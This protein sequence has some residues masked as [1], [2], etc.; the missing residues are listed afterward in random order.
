MRRQYHVDYDALPAATRDVLIDS[1]LALETAAH[2]G[3]KD[4]MKV[5]GITADAPELAGADLCA[6]GGFFDYKYR[7][8]DYDVGRKKAQAFLIDPH[9]PL[10]RIAFAPEPIDPIDATLDGLKLAQMD[11]VVRG[12]VRDR[13]K[14]RILDTLEKA[15][16][17]LLVRTGIYDVYIGPKLTKFLGL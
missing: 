8:H 16:V 17:N 7:K 10:G 6:F 9:C 5:L 4:E 11:R 2:L 12:H 14:Q 1:V 15:G 13:F 3:E